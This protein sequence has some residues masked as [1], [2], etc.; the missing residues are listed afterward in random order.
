MEIV[1]ANMDNVEKKTISDNQINQTSLISC[2]STKKHKF[3][4]PVLTSS[5]GHLT[6][7]SNCTFVNFAWK[8][9]K[10]KYRDD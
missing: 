3:M 5:I 8:T 4:L 10:S 7:Q 9:K 6:T 1:T 2:T